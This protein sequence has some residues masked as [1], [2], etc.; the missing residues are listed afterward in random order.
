MLNA[1]NVQMRDDLWEVLNVIRVDSDVSAVLIDGAGRAFCAG[2][3]LSEFLTA[4][5]PIIARDIRRQRDLWRLFLS[6]K[7]PIVAALHGFVIGSGLE[8]ALSCDIRLC[9]E[10]T[11]FCLPETGYGFIPGAGGTQ[12]LSRLSGQ[13]A[14][15]YHVLTG[16]WFDA[17][18]A[19][20][21]GLVNPLVKS[22]LINKAGLKL[23]N[24]LSAQPLRS[25]QISKEAIRRGLSLSLPE[26]LLLE[27]RLSTLLSEP[28]RP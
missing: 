18:T 7:Q 24:M 17:T 27:K 16:E 26:A 20:K 5:S 14:T 9:A 13:S 4:P 10:G 28:S 19:H 12:L 23:A 8:I 2:A 11:R 3:D 1:F 25:V 6:I 22:H 21:I 15:I